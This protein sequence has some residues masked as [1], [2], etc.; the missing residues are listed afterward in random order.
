MFQSSQE[1]EATG[2]KSHRR[3]RSQ[4]DVYR[5]QCFCHL[6]HPGQHTIRRRPRTFGIHHMYN[7]MTKLGKQG[8][9][10]DNDAQAS[11][12]VSQTAPDQYTLWQ[13]FN[14]RNNCSPCAGKTGNTLQYAIQDIQI[15]SEYV[16]Q[17]PQKSHE[18]PAETGYG[19]SLPDTQIVNG[20][21][22]ASL[23]SHADGKTDNSSS[24]QCHKAGI[25][26]DDG[27][28]GIQGQHHP[29]CH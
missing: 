2:H 21:F 9:E 12:P 4:D 7:A 22:P 13:Y 6:T 1:I 28:D 16:G 20:S 15:S 17:H 26:T 3:C 8:N 11:Q 29:Q 5:K 23:Q 18:D 25:L 27:Y 24:G 10:N 14:V 19:N